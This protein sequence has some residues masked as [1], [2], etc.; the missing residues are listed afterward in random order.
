MPRLFARANQPFDR[1]KPSAPARF[2]MKESVSN[3]LSSSAKVGDAGVPPQASVSPARQFP[4]RCDYLRA[5]PLE[6]AAPAAVCGQSADH[7]ICLL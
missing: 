1:L 3:G 6:L 2:S 4:W 7:L 5:A